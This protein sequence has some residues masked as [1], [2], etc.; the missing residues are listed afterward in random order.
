[1]IWIK[2]ARDK[3]LT[4][5][6]GPFGEFNGPYQKHDGVIV[7]AG[8]IPPTGFLQSAGIQMETKYGAP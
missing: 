1:L 7:C 5:Q 4:M 8:G 6:A 2:R 3:V